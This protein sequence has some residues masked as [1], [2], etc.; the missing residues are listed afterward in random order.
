M[1]NSGK[2]KLN[3]IVDHKGI[4]CVQIIGDPEQHQQ[5]HDLYMFIQDLIVKLDQEIQ[6]RLEN[7]P[8]KEIYNE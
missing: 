7:K 3:I 1:Q 4:E 5:G 8:Q 6:E 2:V